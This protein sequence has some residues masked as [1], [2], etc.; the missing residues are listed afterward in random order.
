MNQKAH[1]FQTVQHTV[2]P[3]HNLSVNILLQKQKLQVQRVSL[4]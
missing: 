4:T 1:C 2:L 3:V